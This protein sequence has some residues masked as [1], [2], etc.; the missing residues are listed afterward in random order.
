MTCQGAMEKRPRNEKEK[1]HIKPWLN[2][3]DSNTRTI[4]DN[5]SFLFGSTNTIPTSG[6]ETV[7]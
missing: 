3:G 6:E 5:I 1:I 2:I 4:V 7:E